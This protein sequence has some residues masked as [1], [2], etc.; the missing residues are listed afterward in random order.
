MRGAFHLVSRSWIGAAPTV[1]YDIASF[2]G[3]DWRV[4]DGRIA[5]RH[6]DR[7]GMFVV[8][9]YAFLT[10]TVPKAQAA[11]TVAANNIVNSGAM[12]AGSTIAAALTYA[13]VGTADQLL[14]AAAMCLGFRLARLAAAQGVRRRRLRQCRGSAPRRVGLAEQGA[15]EVDRRPSRSRRAW[16]SSH[17]AGSAPTKA[18]RLGH[19]HGHRRRTETADAADNQGEQAVHARH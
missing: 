3:H 6:C 17:C 13:G 9:L 16:S 12:V 18:H 7:R 8:P 19:R 14:L 15:E 4:A 11:R 10:T 1:L 2:F 5:A